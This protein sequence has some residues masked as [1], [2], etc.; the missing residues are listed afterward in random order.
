MFFK[1]PATPPQGGVLAAFLR[2]YL[3]L[4]KPGFIDPFDFVIFFTRLYSILANNIQHWWK[5]GED[6]QH[7]IGKKKLLPG[8]GC[9]Q[10]NPTYTG[11]TLTGYIAVYI[12]HI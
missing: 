7:E 8:P 6:Q 5:Y 2:Y 10:L 1:C 9:E 4:F 11:N 3:L 12:H